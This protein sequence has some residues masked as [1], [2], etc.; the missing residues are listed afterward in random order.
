MKTKTLKILFYFIL[1]V[2][3]HSYGQ[4][5]VEINLENSLSVPNPCLPCTPGDI[6]D[7]CYDF[8]ARWAISKTKLKTLRFELNE[9]VQSKLPSGTP[10]DSK[11]TAI[12]IQIMLKN[13]N[14]P[15]MDIN[16]PNNVVLNLEELKVYNELLKNYHQSYQ[17]LNKL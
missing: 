8:C 7:K 13:E 10:F 15:P 11:E 16:N 14:N 17:E 3:L 12:K 4:T 9:I 5:P 1:F 6:S 2:S